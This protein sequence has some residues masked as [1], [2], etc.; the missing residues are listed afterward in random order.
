MAKQQ[1]GFDLRD[2]MRRYANDRS[3]HRSIPLSLD[4]EDWER[5][6]ELA[7]FF[8][9]GITDVVRTAIRHAVMKGV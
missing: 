1:T 9:L 6:V 5:S 8:D 3:G 2:R 7:A 4:D